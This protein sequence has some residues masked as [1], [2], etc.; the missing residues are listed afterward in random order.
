MSV[1]EKLMQV[2]SELKAPKNQYNSFGKYNYRSCEDILEGVKPLLKKVK[3]TLTISDEITQVADR[4]YVK[5]TATFTDVENGETITNSAFA[6]EASDKKGMDESQV[7]GATSSYARK[8]CLN[9]LLCIDDTKDSDT[10]EIKNERNARAEKEEKSKAKIRKDTPEEAKANE[11]MKANVDQ[12]LIPDPKRSPEQ[13]EINVKA[14]IE[15]TGQDEAKLL[16]NAG[17]KAWSELTDA[18]YVSLMEWLIKR[19]DKGNK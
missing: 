12:R 7:T 10:D 17:V 13:R 6:R 19:P 14:E 18:R 15:R 4:I 3:A 11:E 1:Y 16:A 9:G 5:A 8:Y 2:Q